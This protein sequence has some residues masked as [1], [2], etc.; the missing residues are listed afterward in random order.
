MKSGRARYQL[1]Q[2]SALPI[3]TA[4]KRWLDDQRRHVLP[5]SALGKAI[6]Y[7]LGQWT[8]LVRYIDDGYL[9]IDNNWIENAIRP[10]ALG[11]K[12][13]LFAGSPVG[14]HRAAIIYSLVATARKHHVEP[15]A[16]LRDVITRIV[17]HPFHR[18]NQLLPPNRQPAK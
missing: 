4:I 17:E 1:C 14:A 2:R 5:E 3:L 16:Y 15:F 18:L 9:E 6:G 11:R 12:N 8:R 10:L 7:A 13:Y